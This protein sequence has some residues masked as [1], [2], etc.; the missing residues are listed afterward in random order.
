MVKIELGEGEEVVEKTVTKDGR[1]WGLTKYAGRRVMVVV[2]KAE[3]R[4]NLVE[5]I[6][7]KIGMPSWEEE[8]E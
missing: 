6:Y 5:R 1:V 7:G 3:E 4:K 8:E 2:L